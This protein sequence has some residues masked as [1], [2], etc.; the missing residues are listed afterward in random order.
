LSISTISAYNV[1]TFKSGSNNKDRNRH[2]KSS[3]NVGRGL[4]LLWRRFLY[5][6][7][8]AV[9]KKESHT[10][11]DIILPIYDEQDKNCCKY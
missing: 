9:V 11:S 10:I 4:H 3:A 5:P 8:E 2:E 7:W 6:L 1:Q